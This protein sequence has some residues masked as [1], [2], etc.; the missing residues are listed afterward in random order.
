MDKYLVCVLLFELIVLILIDVCIVS[1]KLI[2]YG[3]VE[4]FGDCFCYSI[5]ILI[6]R[7]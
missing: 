7:L 3:E 1:C 4:S 5:V 2:K 6:L